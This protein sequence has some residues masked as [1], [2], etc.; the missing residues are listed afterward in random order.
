MQ[1]FVNKSRKELRK[2]HFLAQF[3]KLTLRR[4]ENRAHSNNKHLSMCLLFGAADF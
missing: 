4:E 1:G 2:Y 3:V